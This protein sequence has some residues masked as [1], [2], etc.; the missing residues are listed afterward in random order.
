[1]EADGSI[2]TA[3]SVPFAGWAIGRIVHG[4]WFLRTMK[5][6]TI[7]VACDGQDKLRPNDMSEIDESVPGADSPGH[8]V[9]IGV[10]CI[11]LASGR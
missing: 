5:C 1:M 2:A 11:L 7:Y 3:S 10:A 4:I 8:H 9:A 6:K